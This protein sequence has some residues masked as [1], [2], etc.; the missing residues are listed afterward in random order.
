[1]KKTWLLLTIQLALAWSKKEDLQTVTLMLQERT[2]WSSMQCAGLLAGPASAK[3]TWRVVMMT[4]HP[5]MMLLL[6][7][8]TEA[9]FT[10]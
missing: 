9:V 10:M 7:P 2:P 8:M 5:T 4:L 1:M 6:R 3:M